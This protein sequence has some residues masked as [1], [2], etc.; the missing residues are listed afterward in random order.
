MLRLQPSQMALFPIRVGL[1]K[2]FGERNLAMPPDV[3]KRSALPSIAQRSWGCAPKPGRSPKFNMELAGR[4]EAFRTSDGT[5]VPL[6]EL[7]GKA[8][9]SRCVS[10]MLGFR[11]LTVSLTFLDGEKSGDV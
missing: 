1:P 4:P 7:F 8:H 10:F 6:K 11:N 3:R 9:L 5:A 2:K